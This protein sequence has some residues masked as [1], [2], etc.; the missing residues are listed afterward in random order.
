MINQAIEKRRS[1]RDYKPDQIP[2]EL[3]LEIIKAGQFAPEAMHKQ[4][5]EF[6]VITNQEIKEK[7]NQV[8]SKQLAQDYV[9]KAP[10]LIIPIA[11]TKKS[12]LP[13]QDLSVATENI[14]IQATELGLGSVWKNIGS[15]SVPEIRQILNL[16]DNYTFINL[17]PIGYAQETPKP[18]SSADFSLEKI[19]FIK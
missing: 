15:E 7:I 14:F 2:N 13:T 1:V 16:T 6:V 3:I 4:G 18:H 5:I 10:V 9:V 8:L 11:D 12:I 17:I 19:R